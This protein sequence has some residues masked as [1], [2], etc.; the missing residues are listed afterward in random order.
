[1]APEGSDGYCATRLI[2][3][4]AQQELAAGIPKLPRRFA[5][6]IGDFNDRIVVQ[7]K[8]RLA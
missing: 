1:V 8:A 3:A 4:N 6:P 7:G 5:C 2:G